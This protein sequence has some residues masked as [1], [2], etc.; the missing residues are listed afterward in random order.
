MNSGGVIELEAVSNFLILQSEIFAHQIN[1]NPACF[2]NDSGAG[3][4]VKIPLSDLVQITD[5]CNDVLFVLV[6]FVY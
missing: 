3:A 5:S 4:F 1:A 6:S 2:R